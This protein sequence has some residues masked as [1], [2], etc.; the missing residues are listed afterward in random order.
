MTENDLQSWK[1]VALGG[2][3]LLIFLIET[4]RRK[5]D[6]KDSR[7]KR[8]P[9]HLIL[10]AVNSVIY[11][12]VAW[13]G[14][15]FLIVWVAEQD[16]GLSNLL[17]LEGTAGILATVVLYDFYDYWWHRANHR[18]PFLWRFHS[19]HHMDTHL[20]VTTGLR[21]HPGELLLS[22]IAKSIF[23]IV[24]GPGL[25]GYVI[26][27]TAISTASFFHHGNYD[28]GDPLEKFA[29][30]FIM[31]PRLHASHHTVTTRT[32]DADYS[33]ILI[34]WD[35]LFGTFRYARKDEVARLGLDTD[36]KKYLSPKKILLS[37]FQ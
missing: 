32:R 3:V 1:P 10:M 13:G 18:V 6:W 27:Q 9:T 37:P 23:I 34:F 21:F 16:V 22:G 20:D 15:Y 30:L 12:F 31:T 24:W 11:K 29:S 25:L 7:L 8:A 4:L 17:G 36:R 5:R 26:A 19:V 33:T 28:L 2:V 14:L 35:R